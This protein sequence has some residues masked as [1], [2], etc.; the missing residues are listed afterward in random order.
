MNYFF[1]N[2]DFPQK[3]LNFIFELNY[4][5]MVD[6]KWEIKSLL[7]LRS[8]RHGDVKKIWSFI[9]PLH[10]LRCDPSQKDKI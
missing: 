1:F 7:L 9:S 10:S 6:L 3:T 8:L 4:Y 2:T 5:G